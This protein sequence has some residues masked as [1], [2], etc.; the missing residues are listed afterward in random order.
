MWQLL[1]QRY[2]CKRLQTFVLSALCSISK[3]ATRPSKT[4]AKRIHALA[5]PIFRATGEPRHRF[6]FATDKQV[7]P[8]IR[9]PESDTLALGP[10][11]SSDRRDFQRSTPT[12]R[13]SPQVSARVST[14]WPTPNKQQR[15]R[16]RATDVQTS[17]EETRASSTGQLCLFLRPREIS[18]L[19]RREPT[20]SGSVS[21]LRSIDENPVESKIIGSFSRLHVL[22]FRNDLSEPGRGKRRRGFARQIFI[23]I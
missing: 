18:I 2:V 12:P 14:R 8:A 7:S 23:E 10:I 19:S 13:R 20:E 17:R 21:I 22:Y 5:V 6:R 9:I 1:F 3:N 11:D 16:A 15:G 4:V